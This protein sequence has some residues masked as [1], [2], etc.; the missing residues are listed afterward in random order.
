MRPALAAALSAAGLL[1]QRP[2]KLVSR[3]CIPLAAASS[4]CLT[5]FCC[6]HSKQHTGSVP[7]AMSRVDML[8]DKLDCR[9]KA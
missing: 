9:N 2:P 3:A 6:Q 8:V 7:T 5:C 4:H 1:L